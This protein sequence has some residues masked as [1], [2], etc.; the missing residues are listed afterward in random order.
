M[1]QD[2][3][4]EPSSAELGAELGMDTCEVDKARAVD[5]QYSARSLD[6]PV[7]HD[8]GLSLGDTLGGAAAEMDRVELF[9]TLRPA[10]CALK[11]RDQLIV[12]LRFVDE[13]TQRQI[14]ERI[15]VSQMQVSR[16]LTDILARLRRV[17][18]TN[19]ASLLAAS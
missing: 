9:A 8:A 12:R 19:D 16:L 15:G 11:P 18:A 4:R 5:G 1:A 17:L 13:L 10:L 7:D 2:L 6:A 14:G 3:G